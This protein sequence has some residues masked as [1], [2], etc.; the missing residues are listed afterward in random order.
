M[1]EIDYLRQFYIE[2][3]SKIVTYGKNPRPR[4]A[5]PG[6]WAKLESVVNLNESA[7]PI[8]LEG[9]KVWAWSDLHFWHKNI[10]A[11]S[12][13]PYDDIEQMHEHLLAN[14]NDYVGKDDVVIWGG[15]IGF[16][17]TTVLNEMLSEYNGYKILIVG[18]HDF[19]GK[20]LRNLAF[21]E[22]HL[23]YTV[24]YPEV[25]M[26]FTH[27]PMYNVPEPWINV[28]GHLHA[29]PNPVSNHPRHLN[30]NCEVQGYKPRL[31]DDIAKQAH[32][33]SIAAEF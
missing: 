3:L 4:V 27:Y 29:F 8:S 10:I 32:M 17:G 24:D 28:H 26:V 31:L 6:K 7:E 16:K 14:H 2:D 25:S 21:D 13:R 12:E 22:T 11:F 1:K 19:N 9:R 18:N 30:I 23:I 15:D 33:L 20:K 5:H